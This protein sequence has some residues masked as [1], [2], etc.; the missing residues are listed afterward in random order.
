MDTTDCK[1]WRLEATEWRLKELIKK[2]Y[3]KIPDA[4]FSKKI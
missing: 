4:F 1:Y 3:I 2:E